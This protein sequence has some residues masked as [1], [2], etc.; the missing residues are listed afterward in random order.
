MIFFWC[1]GF[2]QRLFNNIMNQL[3]RGVVYAAVFAASVLPAGQKVPHVVGRY[4]VLPFDAF[5]ALE[6]FAVRVFARLEIAA[7]EVDVLLVVVSAAAVERLL[8]FAVIHAPQLLARIAVVVVLRGGGRV[9]A[10]FGERRTKRYQGKCENDG[11]THGLEGVNHKSNENCK[12][13][14]GNYSI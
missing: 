3:E 1:I 9:Y 10:R 8:Q 4:H 6:T 14:V 2:F 12:D 11:A 13:V 7:R 5:G